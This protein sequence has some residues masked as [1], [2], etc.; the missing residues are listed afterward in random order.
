MWER[1]IGIVE[2]SC[3]GKEGHEGSVAGICQVF[4]VR[5]STNIS[6]GPGVDGDL[7]AGVFAIE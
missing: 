7:E 1:G 5:P 2:E 3:E 4:V 6:A